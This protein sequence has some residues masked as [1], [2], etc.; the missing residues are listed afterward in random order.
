MLAIPFPHLYLFRRSGKLYDYPNS[1]VESTVAHQPLSIRALKPI[2][3]IVLV[4]RVCTINRLTAPKKGERESERER[5]RERERK[6]DQRSVSRGRIVYHFTTT[7]NFT[8]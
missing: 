3:R 6:R 8:Y 4:C 5:E 7:S 2:G 1:P